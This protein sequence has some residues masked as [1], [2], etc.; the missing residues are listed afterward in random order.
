MEK[1]AQKAVFWD[2]D[3]TLVHAKHL[4]SK[5]IYRALKDSLPETEITYDQLRPLAQRIYTWSEPEK[6]YH[7][8]TGMNWW[9]FMY[10]RFSI[11]YQALGVERSKADEISQNVRAY[12]LDISNYSLYPDTVSTLLSC[13]NMGYCNYVLSNNYPE[14]AQIIRGLAIEQHFA[15]V[16]VSAEIGY[17]K[18]RR[19]IFEYALAHTGYPAKCIMVGDNP[20]ADILGARTVGMATVLV[21]QDTE[22]GADYTIENLSEITAIL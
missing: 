7:L 6:D 2:F 8:L 4:W 21:H 11:V 1:D 18:P 10:G 14:L 13:K 20:V 3:G 17:D 15:S 19:E 22:S 12:I 16:F 9:K 5:S